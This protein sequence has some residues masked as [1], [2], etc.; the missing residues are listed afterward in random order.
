MPKNLIIFRIS[1]KTLNEH[2]RLVKFDRLMN[3][4]RSYTICF[5]RVFTLIL[6]CAVHFRLD[7]SAENQKDPVEVI[8]RLQGETVRRRLWS[9]CILFIMNLHWHQVDSCLVPESMHN[10]TLV[11]E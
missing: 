4:H 10:R 9:F 2:Y 3:T 1:N 7:V 11:Q 5:S 8:S 6:E